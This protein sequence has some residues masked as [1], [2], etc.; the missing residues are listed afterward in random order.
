MAAFY[1]S[2]L[3]PKGWTEKP[4]V[5]N[6]ENM[7]LLEFED[8]DKALS[9]MIMQH[10]DA[11]GVSAHGSALQVADAAGADASASAP[12]AEK[13]LQAEEMSHLPIPTAHTFSTGGSGAFRND[14]SVNVPAALDTVLAFYR[15]EL[16][17]RGWKEDDGAAIK[18]DQA[19][20]AFKAPEGPAV[21]KLDRKNDE[22]VVTLF[23]RHEADAAKSGLLP[24][25]GQ[26]KILLTNLTEKEASIE[27]NKQSI[28][29]KAGA[30]TKAPDG[31]SLELA[32]GKYRYS[33]KSAGKTSKPDEL[34]VGPDEIWGLAVGPG[35]GLAMQIY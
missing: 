32:P 8:G 17:K 23:L 11:V 7:V 33:T 1:R 21:L 10:G 28:K 3:K 14:V 15:R 12:A 30:G 24:K 31:P 34:Q 22:T 4:S 35:G 5:I 19:V 26:V 16:S 25:P 29:I 2:A 27:I 6:R 18:S 13:E 9:L 20:I